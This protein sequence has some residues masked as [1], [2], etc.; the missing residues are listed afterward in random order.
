[1]SKPKRH[2]YVPQMLL[3]NFVDAKGKLHVYRKSDAATWEAS[4]ADTFLERHLYSTI[5]ADGAREPDLERA[6]S[7]LEGQ[8]SQIIASLIAA[9]RGGTVPTLSDQERDVWALFVYQQMKRV[10]EMFRK[11][12]VKRPFADRLEDAIKQLETRLGRSLS[13]EEAADFRAPEVLARLQ[14][15]AIVKALADPGHVVQ[16]QLLSMSLQVALA[17]DGSGFVIGSQPVARTGSGSSF[18]L[19]DPEVHLW[20]PIASDVA[21][22]FLKSTQ[23]TETVTLAADHVTRINRQMLAQSEMIVAASAAS[24]ESLTRSR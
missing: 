21:V 15:N 16:E 11:L 8:A 12:A 10:P 24:L 3:R 18:N 20:L 14:Q 4:P 22:R 19:L 6:Y 1:M 2:H 9:A 5:E 17:P 13:A 7:D 23:P